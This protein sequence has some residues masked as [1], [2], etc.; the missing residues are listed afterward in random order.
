MEFM[1]FQILILIYPLLK[2]EI[3]GKRIKLMIMIM[4]SKFIYLI[5]FIAN[6]MIFSKNKDKIYTSF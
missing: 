5:S 2:L 6:M 1:W 4:I 3:D